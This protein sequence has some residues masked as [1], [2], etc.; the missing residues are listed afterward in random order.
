MSITYAHVV[1]KKLIEF[2][3]NVVLIDSARL[4]VSDATISISATQICQYD[5]PAPTV[6]FTGSG[7][8]VPYIFTYN[9]NN[10]V[11][12]TVMTTGNNN[13]VTVTVNTNASGTYTYNLISVEDNTA[14]VD[15][16]N[17]SVQIQIL[18]SPDTSIGGTGA[19]T[20]FE[21]IPVFRDC[22]NQTTT[23]TFTNTS[24]TG[25]LN[26]NYNISWG[27]GSPDF[28]ETTWSSTTHTYD[29]GIYNLV[30]TI[31]ASNG[32]D[33]TTNYTVFVGSNPAVS[34]GNPGNTDICNSSPLTFP[35]T[36]TDNN[37]PGTTY[38]VTFNDGSAPQT[39]SHP[40]PTSITHTF[41]TSSCDT[42]SSDGTNSYQNSFS[43]IIVASNPCSASSVGVVPIY[44][45]IAPEADF[46]APET[47]CINTQ[48]CLTNTSIGE[49]NN[50]L[51][52]SC[53]TSPNIIW[54][55]SPATGYTI[56][57]G[58]L[59]NDFGLSDPN[60]WS[61]GTDNLCVNF[62]QLGTYTVTLN[63]GNRCGA[64]TIVKT[65]CV[66]DDLVPVFSL[67]TSEGCG[68]LNLTTSNTT[69]EST[70]CE[71][72]EYLWEV[73]Y[74]A[75]NCG[76]TPEQ[77]SFTNGSDEN[78]V[79]P[80]FSFDT[81]G[82]Y[83]LVL[84]A[85][86]SC[87]DFT[88]SQTIEV[89]Q[90]PEISINDVSDGCGPGDI[91]P[92]AIVDTCAP[93]SETII[94]NWS[95]P[96]GTPASAN[97][98][99]PGTINYAIA[100]N[101]TI[102]LSVT[103]DCGTDTVTDTFSINEAPTIT[104][105]DVNQTI[106]SGATTTAINLTSDNTTT[107]YT[108]TSNDPVGLTGYF[109]FGTN[110]EIPAQILINTTTN[111][112][113]LIYTVVPDID[114]CEGDP[115]VFIITVE[116]AP[117]VTFQPIS[118]AICLNGTTPNLSVSYQGAGTPNY[119]WYQNTIDNTT[120]GTAIAGATSS[121]YA[122]PTDTVGDVYYYVVIT[123]ST[124][125]C[126]EISSDTALIE[127]KEESQIDTQPIATQSI[128]IDGTS[129][130]LSI[131][132]SGGAGNPMYQWFSNTT[133]ST[134]GGTLISGATNSTYSPPVFTAT[135][136][137]YFYVEIDYGANGCSSLLSSISEVIVVDDPIVDLQPIAYQSLCQSTIPTDLEVV[138]SG[139][140]GIISYQWYSNTINSNVG[141]TAIAGETSSTFSP[142]TATV[143]TFYY[144]CV[145]TQ[146]VSGCEV[147]SL[148]C[149]VEVTAAAQFTNQPLSDELCLGESSADLVVAYTNG[150]GSPTYQWY[151]NTVNDVT[152]GTAIAGETTASY[153]PDVS[154]VGTTFYYCIITL[155][156]GGCSEIV[157]DVAEIIVNETPY[158]SDGA[159]LIC[160]G[161]VFEHIPDETN[162][163]SVPIN[164]TYT[165]STPII[166]PA[167]SVTGASE[168]LVAQT[169]ISQLL[170]N[171]TTNPGTVTY[172]VT[173]TS[174]NCVGA[175]FEVVVTVNPSIS[176]TSQLTNNSCFESNDAS[177]EITIVGGVPFSGGNPYNILWTGPNAYTSTDEDLFNLSEG[178]YTLNI[179]DDG[180]CP[181]SETFTITEPDIL[182]FSAVTFD[183]ETISC[184]GADDG[185]IS[186]DIA[187]GTLPYTYNW[188]LDGLPFSGNE[189]L[190]SLEPGVYVVSVTDDH[191]CGPISQTFSIV[192]P[193]ILDVTLDTKT[194]VLCFGDNTGA[195][196]INATGG[197]LDYVFS[198][199]GP[200]GFTSDNQNIENLVAGIYSVTV[201][202]A[203]NCTDTL[204]VEIVQ[205][206]E[207]AINVTTTEIECYGNNDG[208]ITIN[209][210]SGGVG[211]Y[212][213]AWSNLGT[214]NNQT[215]LTGGTYIITIT[216]AENCIKDFPVIIDEPAVFLID[217]VV[218]QLSCSGENDAS[219]MLNFVGGIA[220]VDLVWN[221]DPT[222]GTERNN[223]APGTYTVTITDA[224]PCTIEE[225]FTIFDIAPLVVS[226]N[227]TNALDCDDTNSGAIN[228]LIQGGTPPFNVVWSNGEITEDLNNSPPNSYT[229]QV[230]DANG[231]E[232][233]GSWTIERFE[234]LAV[235]VDVQS[236][237]DCDEQSINQLFIAQA[238]GGVPPFAYNWSSGTVSGVNNEQMT[239]SE[240]G[241]VILDVVD[242]LGCSVT[243]SLNVDI[244]VFGQP[245]FE[246]SSVGFTNFG[247][248][249]IHDPIEFTN[250]STGNF[251]SILWN[252]GDGTFSAEENPIHTYTAVGNYVVTQTVTYPFG[253]V[254]EQVV[255]LIVEEGYKLMFP[256][257]F[258]PNEDSLNDFFVPKYMGLNTLEF[259]VYDT[260][261]SLV[262]YEED[263]ESLI[264][265]NGTINDELAENG[266]Y[267]YTFTAK[268]FYGDAI[269]KDG[270][271]VTIK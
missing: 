227:V 14:T 34:L 142:P 210:I 76:T 112:I 121:T 246:V 178:T 108:W 42:T 74:S 183:P 93:S 86:N 195:I 237:V 176:I 131:T 163:D 239:T 232:T 65:I 59:G 117:L 61:T 159:E 19:G 109:S 164:T 217:P 67:N 160:S 140:L 225:S 4:A 118:D 152:S 147:V 39:F 49:E 69:D 32:C 37:P 66:E 224:A 60:L 83:E 91:N 111:P 124:G 53:D 96:G 231:C 167:G 144:Y 252:F 98:L 211:P 197:R 166:N 46:D 192:E 88:T 236:E 97:T 105:T 24:S 141:G 72:P 113:D 134:T 17:E 129:N 188:T 103:N 187:G 116:P 205:N 38:T 215:N 43:A 198:W 202:D 240:N 31:E 92:T 68:P 71:T 151:E 102:T 179:I 10:G 213:V 48:I 133:N 203:S 95:F 27:D 262:F 230:T 200:N 150:A 235:I 35:I 207:I 174:G 238:S 226:A 172:T 267:Y 193:D 79:S 44:V 9:I 158:I 194:N 90:P 130:E 80:S 218:T 169:S 5:T 268:T 137:Y 265:W 84:T 89:K 127:I 184:F 154:V 259:R 51:G 242:S 261:G 30:Y 229:A 196:S 223:L 28:N 209:S 41:S 107:T 100:G 201:T 138:N 110:N 57:S 128:C 220:P 161:N 251:E 185:E 165:W 139:G 173:P 191:N 186:I 212:Q 135:G 136:N 126:N 40:P 81:A 153:S 241:L 263:L 47:A 29:V 63:T 85:T 269:E 244:P 214:G 15:I 250:T 182:E 55:I 99:D 155:N 56:T 245:D 101:Y 260:W 123:F 45:S 143:G 73:N 175:N 204:E 104:N 22:T 189:D 219:I 258:T 146:D 206:T 23:F 234:P 132:V 149:E 2:T 254:Y 36:G 266:N 125:G 16:I 270:V 221:D 33:R 78:S 77:W 82:T 106:C 3:K 257:A 190:D 94:Y 170:T 114:G 13:S 11:D 148:V 156:A 119:Q 171:T 249:S 243:Y 233:S 162:G 253:C 12:Q 199:T 52:S 247:I 115:V 145:I 8:T 6:T 75:T 264:G 62:T 20:T 26:T 120:T 222:A 50:G 157:S 168:E 25:S 122:P 216:D 208:S 271:F 256:N 21:G 255:T 18:P 64:D 1:K 180:G 70:S 7:G 54:D 181:F 228:L 87:G 177:I 248:Y 58:S